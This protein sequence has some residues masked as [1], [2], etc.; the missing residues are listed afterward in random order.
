MAITFNQ[1]DHL[2]RVPHPGRYPLMVS[3]IVGT[4][5]LTK[6]LMDGGNGLNI[7]YAN[8]LDKMGI[9]WSNL[10]PSK[11]PFYRI[12]LGKEAVPLGRIWLII[13]FGQ[14]NNFQKKPLTFEVVDFLGVYH[15]LLGRSCFTKF[16]V[17]PN[18]TY[19]KLKM[20]SPKGIITVK[21]S[22]EQAY[23]CE[24]DCI[25]QAATLITPCAPN[26]PS[27]DIGRTLAEEATK[28]V[29]VLDL[30]SIGKAVKTSSGSGRSTSPHI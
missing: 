11:V 13:T 4:M 16:M 27:H 28:M 8:T 17:S 24:Q 6:L 30:P 26:G 18:Y 29:V 7:L 14:P 5:C 21:G 22:F 12:M 10:L 25:T 9:P 23:C 20:P 2:D 15:A 19:L 3:P 1:E